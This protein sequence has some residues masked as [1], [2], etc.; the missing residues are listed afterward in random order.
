M[1]NASSELLSFEFQNEDVRNSEELVH[2]SS[3]SLQKGK[4]C[5][6]P[7]LWIWDNVGSHPEDGE[8]RNKL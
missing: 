1:K 7:L 8:K 2:S 5:H 6:R 3:I 4:F